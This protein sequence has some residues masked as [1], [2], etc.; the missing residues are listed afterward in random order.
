MRTYRLLLILFLPILQGGF[1]IGALANEALIKVT[2]V[3]EIENEV[4]V[5][6][7]KVLKRAT[8]VKVIPGT[9]VIFTNTFTNVSGK[10][11][12]NI[13]INN[14]ISKDTLYQAGSAF[15]KD[16]DIE[17]SVDGGRKFASPELLKINSPD[18]KQRNALPGDYTDIR[19]IYKGSLPA[20]KLGEV[21][22]RAV[23][24]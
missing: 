15:G 6:G 23:V 24:K 20:G 19:W 21:G 1:S 18:G 16:T 13:T 4:V 7:I 12:S 3:V 8:P 14:P 5:N 10:I 11:A 9:E 22:F 2:G 17:F